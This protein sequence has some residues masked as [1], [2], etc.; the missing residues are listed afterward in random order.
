MQVDEKAEEAKLRE[1]RTCLEKG[2]G[3]DE[4]NVVKEIYS[5]LVKLLKE[6]GDEKSPTE[7][8]FG[9]FA[10]YILRLKTSPCNFFYT[11]LEDHITRYANEKGISRSCALDKVAEDVLNHRG[12]RI[13]S[14]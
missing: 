10:E 13:G 4:G 5:R 7:T 2:V 12:K 14:C 6:R 9:F 8:A 3:K 11:R 1:I